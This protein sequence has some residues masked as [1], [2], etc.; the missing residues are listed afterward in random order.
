MDLKEVLE[1]IAS[2]PTTARIVFEC[3]TKDCRTLQVFYTDGFFVPFGADTHLIG[4]TKE[5]S[6]NHDIIATF[7]TIGR[8]LYITAEEMK[9]NGYTDFRVIWE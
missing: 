9:I 7:H 3:K 6:D 2:K 8:Y 1:F 4:P 5:M